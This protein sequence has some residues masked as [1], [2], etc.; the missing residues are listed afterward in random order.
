MR[1]AAS[2]NVSP[3]LHEGVT[4]EDGTVIKAVTYEASRRQLEEA[5]EILLKKK[6]DFSVQRLESKQRA[7][8]KQREIGV[9]PFSLSRQLEHDFPE[10]FK[11]ERTDSLTGNLIFCYL[12][13]F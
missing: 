12:F 7:L 2:A 1:A 4:N 8:R 13:G 3:A 10:S 6:F 11:E 9:E 5:R